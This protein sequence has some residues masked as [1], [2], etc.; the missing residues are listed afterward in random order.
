MTTENKLDYKDIA[1][2]TA[3]A[4]YNLAMELFDERIKHNEI[5]IKDEVGLP[6]EMMKVAW[7]QNYIIEKTGIDGET[8]SKLADEM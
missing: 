2:K 7:V 8:L 6:I 5:K 1:M 4:V 3:N